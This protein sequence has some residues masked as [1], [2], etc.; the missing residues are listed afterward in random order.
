MKDFEDR[1]VQFYFWLGRDAVAVWL[2]HVWTIFG[3]RDPP[4]TPPAPDPLR[5]D[6]NLT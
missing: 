6:P 5:S 4:P 2:D 1:V 3:W